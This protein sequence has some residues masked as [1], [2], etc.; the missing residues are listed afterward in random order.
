MKFRQSR[1]LVVQT[2]ACVAWSLAG[3]IALIVSGSVLVH[4]ADYRNSSLEELAKYNSGGRAPHA[5]N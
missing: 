4:R 1:P 2:I 5:L 3:A